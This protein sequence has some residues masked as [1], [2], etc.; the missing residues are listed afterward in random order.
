MLLDLRAPSHPLLPSRSSEVPVSLIS[1]VGLDVVVSGT[2][3]VGV[4]VVGVV[5]VDVAVGSSVVVWGCVGFD[6]ATTDVAVR[7]LV[8]TDV[9]LLVDVFEGP[10]VA[11]AVRS[12]THIANATIECFNPTAP[13]SYAH[14]APALLVSY[15]QTRVCFNAMSFASCV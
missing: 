6:V 8:G 7:L 4:A 14:P 11:P 2:T 1:T 5:G 10:S 3:A 15:K 13:V 9:G 12:G